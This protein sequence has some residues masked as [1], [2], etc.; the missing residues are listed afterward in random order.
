MVKKFLSLAVI[1][2]FFLTSLGPLPCAHADS[3]LGLPAPGTMVNLSPAYAPVIIKGLTVHKDNPFLF[4]FI[5]DVGQDRMSGEPL[6]KEGEKLIKYFLA[7]L[8]IPDKDVWVNL[9]PYEKNRMIPEALGQTDMGRDLLEQDYI[10]KQ[11]TASLIYPEKQLGKTF[12]DEVYSKAQQ[13]YGTTQ[14]PVNTFNKVWIMADRAE[15]FE[16][17]QTAFVVDSHLKVMLEEDYLALNK[18]SVIASTTTVIP[19]KAG[20]HSLGS[21]IIRQIIL[22]QLEKEVNTGKNFANLRQI[23]NS[24]ILSSWYKKNLKEALLNQ[25]YADKSRVKGINLNDPTVK[26]QIYEQYLKAYK[27]G[28]F[29]Y[30]KEDVNNTGETMPRKYFSGGILEAGAAADPTRTADVQKLD[31]AMIGLAGRMEDLTTG[32]IEKAKRTANAAMMV[33]IA[34]V[35]RL[36]PEGLSFKNSSRN[37]PYDMRELAEISS[38]FLFVNLRPGEGEDVHKKA[39]HFWFNP[40]NDTKLMND[41]IKDVQE[42]IPKW[43]LTIDSKITG[44]YQLSI[45]PNAYDAYMVFFRTLEKYVMQNPNPDHREVVRFIYDHYE[46]G[47]EP[48]KIQ[49]VPHTN[50]LHKGYVPGLL[51]F[52]VNL[53]ILESVGNDQW[54]VID[55]TAIA[56]LRI[57]AQSRLE[58]FSLPLQEETTSPSSESPLANAL[59][60][61]GGA[62]YLSELENRK[63]HDLN[64]GERDVGREMRQLSRAVRIARKDKDEGKLYEGELKAAIITFLKTTKTWLG[65]AKSLK[66]DEEEKLD[67]EAGK[68]AKNPDSTFQ[69]IDALSRETSSFPSP[70]MIA[71][72]TVRPEQIGGINKIIMFTQ[73]GTI[74]ASLE[75]LRPEMERQG[76]EIKI[77]DLGKQNGYEDALRFVNVN[78]DKIACMV[79]PYSKRVQSFVGKAG[80]I[81]PVFLQSLQPI[82]SDLHKSI[83]EDI[84]SSGISQI[85]LVAGE[86]GSPTF[87]LKRMN[88]L[89]PNWWPQNR[90]LFVKVPHSPELFKELKDRR[91]LI[92]SKS[93]YQDALETA[94]NYKEGIAA[95]YVSYDD[96]VFEFI[97]QLGDKVPFYIQTLQDFSS[98]LSKEIRRRTTSFGRLYPNIRVTLIAGQV[99]HEDYF[100]RDVDRYLIKNRAM[101]AANQDQGN[102]NTV[103]E[104]LW[105]ELGD[106]KSKKPDDENRDL[107]KQILSE[108]LDHEVPMDFLTKLSSFFSIPSQ[109]MRIALTAGR[110]AVIFN[111]R[112]LSMSGVEYYLGRREEKTDA[113]K[114]IRTGVFRQDIPEDY[115]YAGDEVSTTAVKII[116]T[117]MGRDSVKN[118]LRRSETIVSEAFLAYKS[119]WPNAAMVAFSYT[120]QKGDTSIGIAKRSGITVD[121]LYEDNGISLLRYGLKVGQ[122]IK[123]KTDADWFTY[124]VQAG[125]RRMYL[126]SR[127]VGITAKKLAQLNGLLVNKILKRGEKLQ[128]VRSNDP[129][130]IADAMVTA[131]RER[132]GLPL[133]QTGAL[134]W[135]V[136]GDIDKR[137]IGVY[138]SSAVKDQETKDNI[139]GVATTMRENFKAMTNRAMISETDVIQS[140]IDGIDRQIA[141]IAGASPMNKTIITSHPVLKELISTRQALEAELKI[142]MERGD[143]AMLDRRQAL[144]LAGGMAATAALTAIPFVKKQR[145]PSLNSPQKQKIETVKELEKLVQEILSELDKLEFSQQAATFAQINVKDLTLGIDR[146]K[147]EQ[148]TADID[149]LLKALTGSANESWRGTLIK[150]SEKLKALRKRLDSTKPA[151]PQA[152]NAAMVVGDGEIVFNTE[153]GRSNFSTGSFVDLVN[154]ISDKYDNGEWSS[155]N[156]ISRLPL[157]HRDFLYVDRYGKLLEGLLALMP[158]NFHGRVYYKNSSPPGHVIEV[159]ESKFPAFL[160]WLQETEKDIKAASEWAKMTRRSVLFSRENSRKAIEN[161]LES[162]KGESGERKQGISSFI[163]NDL[164]EAAEFARNQ[165]IERIKEKTG[166]N[167]TVLITRKGKLRLNIDTEH[168]KD[169][170]DLLKG[171]LADYAM[172]GSLATTPQNLGGIDLNTQGMDWKIGKDGRG[173]EMNVDPAMIERIRR[174]GIDSL[175]PVIFRI[176]PVASIWPLMGLEPP[177]KEELAEI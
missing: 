99:P 32:L 108:P 140:R 11:I 75:S 151:N 111:L 150:V 166:W 147:T 92:T 39:M 1:S 174:E 49:A 14:V 129:V 141:E 62:H 89:L 17:N 27:K 56:N 100:L 28:V 168:I 161:V 173:V 67:E 154:V 63:T 22:P 77:V 48:F 78:R 13:M 79:G 80:N 122:V 149:K 23:F 104:I 101:L 106:A 143:A 58:P 50:N 65:L 115:N 53:G 165:F 76:F 8:A 3:V 35:M 2:C 145:K 163:L 15:V 172:N 10:L 9:S 55:Q 16:H 142:V 95:V 86:S 162:I 69:A 46:Q 171:R 110:I 177:K 121:K 96:Q 152:T 36:S 117:G 34:Q 123:I 126:V 102:I 5:L 70:A 118:A 175:S 64:D 52:L 169:L 97:K 90:I 153:G 134:R 146:I 81:S 25:V 40:E 45:N 60:R 124:A 73:G 156:G 57:W 61:A 116:A 6:K 7:S 26:Q 71:Q 51:Q 4:D 120:I 125:D 133:D 144:A 59:M 31:Y 159:S 107:L 85:R 74:S 38:R 139:I 33:P 84:K 127:K 20:I 113:A 42:N 37:Q 137:E 24:I 66:L 91:L 132:F 41:F 128:V 138:L 12:W 72:L 158:P 103:A 82:D 98:P 87:I 157:K 105:D 164:D 29:N 131:L 54:K 135:Y 109:D 167:L 114:A 18:H 21:Q 19:A 160:E 47:N 148:E 130:K 94:R 88:D 30:I 83:F 119:M 43:V 170:M 112:G 155:I 44:R 176:T 136:Q 93:N 68:I